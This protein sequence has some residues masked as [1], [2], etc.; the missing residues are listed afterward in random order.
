MATTGR[1]LTFGNNA[2][3]LEADAQARRISGQRIAFGITQ[4]VVG[5]RNFILDFQ[6]WY[7]RMRFAHAVALPILVTAGSR[8]IQLN[9]RTLSVT[10]KHFGHGLVTVWSR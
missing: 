7:D 2:E 4:S 3:Q 1:K 5:C 6:T 10:R 8:Q 9:P